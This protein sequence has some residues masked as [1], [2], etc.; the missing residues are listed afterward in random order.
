MPRSC[1]HEV[2]M[3]VVKILVVVFIVRWYNSPVTQAVLCF[4]VFLGL[5]VFM[6]FR[7]HFIDK[8]GE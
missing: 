8:D 6:Y 3:M 4:L 5:S 1:Y 2:V 7:P